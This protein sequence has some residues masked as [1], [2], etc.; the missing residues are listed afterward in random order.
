MHTITSHIGDTEALLGP[1]LTS[2]VLFG[3][4]PVTALLD[5]GSPSTIVSLDFLLET[6]AK[7]RA[8]E[9][10]PQEWRARIESRMEPPSIPLCSYG[11]QRLNMVCQ[12]SVSIIRGRRTVTAKVQVQK[13]AP[14]RL[15]IGTDLL[16][17]VGFMLLKAES[18]C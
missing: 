3:G 7:Q 15:L 10:T 6:L 12:T 5:T 9:E 16:P 18:D 2:E 1:T 17:R 14:V 11:G 8:P 4:C 13:G